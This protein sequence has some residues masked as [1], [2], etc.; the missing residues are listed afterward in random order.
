MSSASSNQSCVYNGAGYDEMYLSGYKNSDVLGEERSLSASFLR[1]DDLEIE[2]SEGGSSDGLIGDEPPIQSIIGPDGFRD[3]ILLPLWTVND[4]ISKIKEPH[5]KTLRDKYQIPINI[6]MRLP[7]KS[8]KCYYEGLEDIGIYEQ[9]LK[10][11][12]RYSSPLSPPIPW[13]IRQPDLTKCLEGL[14]KCKGLIWCYVRQS[15]EA[16]GGRVFSLLPSC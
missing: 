8:E 14:F 3:F 1:D 16:D 7:Y 9:M 6:P 13:I 5:F 15:T 12:L 4:F 2:R 10:A 11:G